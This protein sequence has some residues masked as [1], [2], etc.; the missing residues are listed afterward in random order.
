V[1]QWAAED[2]RGRNLLASLIGVDQQCI[3]QDNGDNWKREAARMCDIYE[4]SEITI[5]GTK[6]E[7]PDE[8]RYSTTEPLQSTARLRM[9]NNVRRRPKM[10]LS[11]PAK[12]RSRRPLTSPGSAAGTDTSDHNAIAPPGVGIPGETTELSNAAFLP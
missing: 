10:Q 4:N 8:G 7:S 2:L 6:A 9:R 11:S 12:F 3:V 1:S 5:D